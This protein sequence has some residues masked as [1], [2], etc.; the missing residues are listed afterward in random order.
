[1]KKKKKNNK[2]REREREKAS[3]VKTDQCTQNTHKTPNATYPLYRLY[4]GKVRRDERLQLVDWD[5]KV[6]SG[7]RFEHDSSFGIQSLQ[8]KAVV[9]VLN[10]VHAR[11]T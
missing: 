2:E 5:L 1:M 6:V 8:P 3:A 10:C 9:L 4:L 7:S 11:K